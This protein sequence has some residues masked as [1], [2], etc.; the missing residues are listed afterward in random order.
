VSKDLRKGNT[1]SQTT[2]AFHT[3]E[4]KYPITT[5]SSHLSQER[6][7]EALKACVQFPIERFRLTK[8]LKPTH[9]STRCFSF[10]TAC[11]ITKYLLPSFHLLRITCLDI[12]KKTVRHTKKKKKVKK[13]IL[14]RQSNPWNLT[15]I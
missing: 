11:L 15:Q 2:L 14:K 10:P 13:H 5:Y 9:R 7:G 4:K 6:D 12:K 8:R 1:Q 3:K